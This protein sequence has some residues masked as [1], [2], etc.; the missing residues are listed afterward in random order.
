[1]VLNSKTDYRA[2]ARKSEHAAIPAT[3]DWQW[4]L[5]T[6]QRPLVFLLESKSVPFEHEQW[7]NQ[8]N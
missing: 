8:D 1:M 6:G 2:Q 4:Y 5:T 7:K 3:Q